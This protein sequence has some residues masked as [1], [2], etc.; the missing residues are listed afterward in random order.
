MWKIITCIHSY[1]AYHHKITWYFDDFMCSRD[2]YE[3][4]KSEKLYADTQDSPCDYINN[5]RDISFCSRADAESSVELHVQHV[6]RNTRQL[7][8]A[9]WNYQPLH[10]TIGIRT[11]CR[12][13]RPPIV[14]FLFPVTRPHCNFRAAC[15]FIITFDDHVIK[16]LLFPACCWAFVWSYRWCN[17]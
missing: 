3:Y 17:D 4:I 13:I 5:W 6:R 16:I 1:I 8:Q 2:I 12:F 9:W 7:W 14:N 15:I 11:I 10:F